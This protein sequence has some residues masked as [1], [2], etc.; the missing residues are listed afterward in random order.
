MFR[1]EI[2]PFEN[3][4][5]L[6]SPTMHGEELDYMQQAYH[7]NWMSTVGANIDSIEQEIAGFIGV[8]RAVG[9]ATGTAALHLCVKLAG[10]G[11]GV[12]VACSDMTFSATVNPV[13]YEGG[14]PVFIDT[15]RDTWNMDPESLCKAFDL[16]PSIK[17]VVSANLYGTPAKL[18][19]IRAICE[20]H[21]AVLIEDAAESLGATY[22][23]RQTGSFGRFN[24]ISFNGNKIITGSAG[25]MLL[26]D[27]EQA[28]QRVRKW[29][30]Q[31][32][33]AAPWYQHSELG[34]NYRISNVI[35]GVV[36]GQ[37]PHLQEHI[38]QKKAIYERYRD[39]LKDLPVRMNPFDEQNS[40]PNFWLSC[41]LIDEE[42]MC[43]QTRSDLTAS[44]IP[45]AGKSCP[46][47]ILETLAAHNAEGRPIWKPMH[48]Q[49]IYR[50]NP[51]VKACE[52]SAGEDIFRRGLCLPSDNKMTPAQQDK[53]IEIIK[54]CFM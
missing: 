7:T 29:S 17:A 20:E 44:Y 5:W 6:S 31:S 19:E 42:A 10:V 21:G 38:A 11:P 27:D 13:V 35:A 28:A 8:E 18:D 24:A 46:T 41:L 47:E 26:T 1:N 53:I 39:G 33:D 25:G 12:Q 34:Y 3:R 14:E 48:L 36:R 30:T 50:D 43:E 45:T 9:L 49:P 32:R 37:F 4:V 2:Q 23:G 15:E 52:Q 16:Y 22:Q 40:V 54:A 51:F